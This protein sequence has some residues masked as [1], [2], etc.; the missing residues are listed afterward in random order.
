MTS[1]ASPQTLKSKDERSLTRLGR[2][3]RRRRVWTWLC[4]LVLAGVLLSATYFLLVRRSANPDAIWQAGENELS[5][6]RIQQAESAM[7]RLS[8]LREPTPLD[9]LFRAQVHLA[10]GRDDDCLAELEQL[11]DTHPMSA[12]ARLMA[13]QVELR[14]HRARTAEEHLRQA[15][16]LDPALVKAHRELIYILGYQL[17]R[18][19]LA[20]EF[21]KL[22]ELIELTFDNVFHWCLMRTAQWEPGSAIEELSRFIE[23]EPEDRWSRLALAENYRRMGLFDDAEAAIGP[24]ADNDPEALAI[25][26]MLALDRHQDEKADQ[27][28]NAGPANHPTLA[29]L[30]GRQALARRD[31]PTAV[32]YLRIAYAD[33]PDSRETIFGLINALLMQGEARAAAPLQ[34]R[35]TKLDMLN[36]LIQRAALPQG[37]TDVGLL[38][39]LGSACEGLDRD[40]EARAWYKQA[41]ALDPLDPN[42]QQALFRIDAKLKSRANPAGGEATRG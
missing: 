35:A 5:A 19:D 33:S 31:P 34:E 6:G 37:S 2:M 1:R 12:Q 22:S 9:R 23:A 36:T 17:R 38:R 21:K 3:T 27:L 16:R 4:T 24:L 11:P 10:R 15:I 29:R 32:R 7:A 30:R 13:G 41:I 39:E 20:A 14:R 40:A 25:R 42:A 18:V 8:R 28:L 26:V